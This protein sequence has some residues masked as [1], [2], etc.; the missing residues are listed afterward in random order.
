MGRSV[1]GMSN[2]QL[3]FT[4][5]YTP[6]QLK[7]MDVYKEVYG[8]KEA[9]RL[10]S[11]SQWPDSWYNEADPHGWLQWYNRYS[12]GRR[13]DDDER[14]IKRWNAFKARHGGNMFQEDPTP[15]RAYALRNWAV[16]P[17]KLVKDPEK[18]VKLQKAME[19]YR[20]KKYKQA[21]DMEWARQSGGIP[22]MGG[23]FDFVKDKVVPGVQQAAYNF[24]G[25]AYDAVSNFLKPKQPPAPGATAN[26]FKP[27]WAKPQGPKIGIG[28]PTKT[29]TGLSSK[30]SNALE[31]YKKSVERPGLWENIRAK[32]ARGE[33][34]AKPGEEGY[35]DKKQWKRLTSKKAELL[36]GAMTLGATKALLKT[37][38]S[39]GINIY[40]NI[41]DLV[42]AHVDITD[43]AVNP[44]KNSLVSATPTAS[45]EDISLFK[46]FL[47]SNGPGYMP[48]IN[49]IYSPKGNFN[50]INGSIS[51]RQ[52]LFH[53]GGH[54][55][56]FLEDPKLLPL[57]AKRLM[58]G[59]GL[60]KNTIA[61]E[62]IANNN[63]INFMREQK[64]PVKHIDTYAKNSAIGYNSYLQHYK[65]LNPTSNS[66]PKNPFSVEY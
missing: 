10:A 15:R 64:V 17:L 66:I 1:K 40:R 16:D 46:N 22:E 39:Q 55:M 33:K 38:K 2:N 34:A 53:E 30:I 5:D 57:M 42:K 62:R 48:A 41:D 9:P 14:Q 47:L 29:F 27:N 24:G 59:K 28:I 65:N 56:H 44:T 4:P 43:K 36:K 45:K 21:A 13:I 6:E 63:A 52:S 11:L 61:A 26:A 31:L 51:P 23:A 35:P 8:P 7:A 37:L 12:K 58:A 32:R 3:Q 60:T 18:R 25:K 50:F 54:A 49:A 20:A 19:E